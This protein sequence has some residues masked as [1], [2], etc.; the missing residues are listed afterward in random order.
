MIPYELLRYWSK[1][2]DGQK[3]DTQT[4]KQKSVEVTSDNGARQF[5]I[6]VLSVFGAFNPPYPISEETHDVFIDRF[7]AHIQ[8]AVI[9]RSENPVDSI[10]GARN[11]ISPEIKTHL[12]RQFPR[13]PALLPTTD[14]NQ[15][16]QI[17]YHRSI[18]H[19]ARHVMLIAK[20]DIQESD[21]TS[22]FAEDFLDAVQNGNVRLRYQPSKSAKAAVSQALMALPKQSPPAI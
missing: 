19:V 4:A 5:G 14:P 16:Q 11:T 21:R 9:P 17:I 13:S 6:L 10:N 15:L 3:P 7:A 1:I 12:R 8:E 2:G 20:H 22:L 18:D